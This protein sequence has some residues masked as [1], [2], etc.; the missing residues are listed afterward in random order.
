MKRTIIVTGAGRGLGL[1]IT[2]LLLS[3]G[4]AVTAISRSRSEGISALAQQFDDLTFIEYDLEDIDG[5]AGLCRQIIADNNDPKN[6]A[7]FGLVNN[8]ALGSDGILGTMHLAD[9]SQLLDVNVKAPILL[10]KYFSR[11]MMASA[12][13]GRIINIGS[14]I[15]STGYSGLSVYGASKAAMEGFS[16]SL[17][18]EL[19]RVGITVNV[20]APGYMETDM[21]SALEGGKLESIRR[22]SAMH[23]FA[24]PEDVAGMVSYLLSD[25]ADRVTGT[26]LTVDAG[27][28]A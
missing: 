3:E 11:A 27:S 9:I 7:I 26:V 25:R 28:T 15:G 24:R 8:A 2:E 16:R 6:G 1:A 18:R 10:A 4:F 14:I 23:T 20:V 5:I 17:A 19:G 21:T 12:V 13:K 22:R